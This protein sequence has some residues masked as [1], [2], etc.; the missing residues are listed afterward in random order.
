[1]WRHACNLT[2]DRWTESG[3]EVKRERERGGRGRVREG[4]QRKRYIQRERGKKRGTEGE[5]QR[6]RGGKRQRGEERRRNE[7]KGDATVV[8]RARE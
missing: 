5:R 4:R 2:E 6:E 8:I 7:G 1:M 3:R